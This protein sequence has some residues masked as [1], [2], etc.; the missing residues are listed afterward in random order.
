MEI[1]ATFIGKDSLGY[2]HG[3]Q[4]HL[5]VINDKKPV[6]MR[7]DKT[8]ICPYGSFEKFLENWTNILHAEYVEPIK[9]IPN[10]TKEQRE[11]FVQKWNEYMSKSNHEFHIIPNNQEL[12]DAVEE[13][14][15]HGSHRGF[16]YVERKD[17]LELIDNM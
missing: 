14:P 2:V 12:R 15:V 6:I 7:A 8:G 17:V 9:L 13:L 11:E 4:Y 5:K 16:D 1:I 10:M 3:K